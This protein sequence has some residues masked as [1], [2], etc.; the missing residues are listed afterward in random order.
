[1]LLK[2]IEK[3]KVKMRLRGS[4]NWIKKLDYQAKKQFREQ[5]KT[6]S[7]LEFKRKKIILSILIIKE[8]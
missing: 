3:D 4:K 7:Y 6:S 5:K 1:M 2:I 8:I